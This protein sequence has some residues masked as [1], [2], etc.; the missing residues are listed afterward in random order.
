[1]H[2]ESSQLNG[3]CSVGVM[4]GVA[5]LHYYRRTVEYFCMIHFASSRYGPKLIYKHTGPPKRAWQ[6]HAHFTL[7]KYCRK[8]VGYFGMV[9]F[10]FSRQ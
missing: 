8:T 6:D 4:R 5:G 1:M 7:K 10:E 2:Q 3:Q 9:P